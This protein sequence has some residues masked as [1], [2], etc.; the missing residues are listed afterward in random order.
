MN[1][2]STTS[3]LV[4]RA[5]AAAIGLLGLFGGQPV[6]GKSITPAQAPREWVAYA[7]T[8]TVTVGGWLNGGEQPAPH[9]RAALDVDQVPSLFQLKIWVARDGRIER[10]ETMLPPNSAAEH[11]L[12]ALLVGRRLPPPPKRMRLP[13]RLALQLKA[14][15]SAGMAVPSPRV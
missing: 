9:L 1:H 11:D 5:G 13:V 14:A 4:G 10:V 3:A 7:E 15:P 6:A 12:H 8:M 2:R